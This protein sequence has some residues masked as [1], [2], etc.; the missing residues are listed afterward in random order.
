MKAYVGAFLLFAVSAF[1]AYSEAATL[2][3]S[4]GDEATVIEV[5][6][7]K[8]HPAPSG[9]EAGKAR[10]VFVETADKN[11]L[12]VTTRIALDG[13]WVGAN[14]GNSY[15]ESTVL[16]G[17]YHVCADWQLAHRYLKDSPAFDLFTAEAGKTYYFVVKVAWTAN[18]NAVQ[19]SRYD[20][21]MTLS[22][23]AVNGD[24]GKYL[25]QNSKFATAAWKK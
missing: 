21:D 24:E 14:K 22:L 10:V 19:V 7:H 16:P 1:T 9:L 5:A 8:D 15:F 18:V 3:P 25:V 6:T 2:P 4:C 17:E 11:A 20:G 13:N 12:P 23:S